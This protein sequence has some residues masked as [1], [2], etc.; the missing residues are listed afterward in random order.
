[1]E[2]A[3]SEMIRVGHVEVPDYWVDL[4]AD[5]S[6]TVN[7]VISRSGMRPRDGSDVNCY[8]A[9]D[10]V[11]VTGAVDPGQ[12]V[13]VGA[14]APE[15]KVPI[16]R[17][18]S[19]REHLFYVKWERNIG[20]NGMS[21]GSG[22]LED[23]CTLWVPGM[24]GRL[25]SMRKRAVEI[26]REVNANGKMHAQGY[27]FFD[28]DTPYFPGDLARI[29]TS[30]EDAFRLYDPETG[31]LSIPVRIIH[32]DRSEDGNRMTFRGA[33]HKEV[34]CGRRFLWGI[35]ILSFDAERRVALA[36]VEEELTW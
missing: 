30:G 4:H 8:L 14:S 3:T 34:D 15:V 11:L 21:I 22:W 1:M 31:R 26:T 23:G 32:E 35:R 20:E 12:T 19:P 9:R 18:I 16:D 2:A 17:R 29:T 33:K 25:A 10:G 13:L 6:M 28:S 36:F 27:T 24:E 7:D 5:T